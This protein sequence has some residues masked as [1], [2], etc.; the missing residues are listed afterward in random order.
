MPRVRQLWHIAPKG[1]TFGL[2]RPRT[3]A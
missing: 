1:A 2:A 3:S